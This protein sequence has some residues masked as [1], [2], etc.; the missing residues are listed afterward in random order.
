MP[1]FLLY[2]FPYQVKE[3]QLDIIYLSIFNGHE[4]KN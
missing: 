3:V 1:Q 4:L 2:L